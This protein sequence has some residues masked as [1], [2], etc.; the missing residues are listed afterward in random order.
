ME[1]IDDVDMLQCFNFVYATPQFYYC[2]D[3][4]EY[5]YYVIEMKE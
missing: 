1:Y 4:Q 2:E 3:H 5:D